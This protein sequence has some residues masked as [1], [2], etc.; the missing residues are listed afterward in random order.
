[1]YTQFWSAPIF[2][3]ESDS[4][5]LY[6]V[7]DLR[8]GAFET[9]WIRFESFWM[10]QKYEYFTYLIGIWNVDR[11]PF[12]WLQAPLHYE[13]VR[14]G[15]ALRPFLLKV[16]RFDCSPTL[17]NVNTSQSLTDNET[18]LARADKVICI[19]CTKTKG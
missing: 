13:G 6:I 18:P 17:Y 11:D 16:H 5:S 19:Y 1:M 10:Y 12:A 14:Q 4:K 15:C 2:S 9:F 8:I 3:L 7:S